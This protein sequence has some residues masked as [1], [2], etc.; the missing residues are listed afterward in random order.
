MQIRHSV[1]RGIYSRIFCKTELMAIYRCKPDQYIQ[2][3]SCY[4]V[5]FVNIPPLDTNFSFTLSVAQVT[6]RCIYMIV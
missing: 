3:S 5:F 6:L 2:K 4:R 1:L